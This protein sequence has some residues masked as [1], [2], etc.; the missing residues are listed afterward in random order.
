[1]AWNVATEKVEITGGPGQFII[2]DNS[3]RMVRHS[4]DA[5]VEWHDPTF[6]TARGDSLVE[7]GFQP[8][9]AAFVVAV[10][11]G[12]EPESSIASAYGTMCL[13]E[14]IAHSARERRPVA[15]ERVDLS[16]SQ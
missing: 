16:R 4:G 3:V 1:M 9:L 14:A 8:E 15:V 6:S 13:Y 10:Q 12:H 7:T 5:I 2:L 11:E